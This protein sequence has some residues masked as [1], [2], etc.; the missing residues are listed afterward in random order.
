VGRN[1]WELVLEW[2]YLQESLLFD[3]AASGCVNEK[4]TCIC[5]CV[6]QLL[7][8]N[9]M[10]FNVCAGTFLGC[11]L[12]KQRPSVCFMTELDFCVIGCVNSHNNRCWSV[13]NTIFIHRCY[14]VIVQ[15]VG[16][17]L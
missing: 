14:Y 16:R 15:L 6:I 7:F 12:G 11:V 13:E 17:V 3:F 8:T 4:E 10:T 9:C 2:N 5:I 1:L